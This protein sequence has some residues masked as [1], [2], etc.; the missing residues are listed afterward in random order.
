MNEKL[1]ERDVQIVL[2]FAKN[3]MNVSKTAQELFF[4]RNTVVYHLDKVERMTGLNPFKFYDLM[5]LVSSLKEG[6]Q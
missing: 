2:T 6:E 3:N 5:K 4:H 1:T